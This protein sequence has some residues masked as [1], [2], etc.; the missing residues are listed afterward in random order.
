MACNRYDES[1]KALDE[2]SM[3][4]GFMELGF[5]SN[6]YGT[7]KIRK[8]KGSYEWG[9]DDWSGMYWEEIPESLYLELKRYWEAG[10]EDNDK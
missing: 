4:S 10:N 8:E 7:L 5:I 1:D 6:Y 9:L 3:E 2:E